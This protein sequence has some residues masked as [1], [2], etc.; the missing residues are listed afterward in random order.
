MT[1]YTSGSK[2]LKWEQIGFG[3]TLLAMQELRVPFV[4]EQLESMLVGLGE[5]FMQFAFSVPG[6]LERTIKELPSLC[7]APLFPISRPVITGT[8]HSLI[9][10]IQ[11]VTTA[12]VCSPRKRSVRRR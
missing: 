10:E 7:P 5:Q 8:S 12:K 3:A 6:Y 9:R 2:Q 1:H 11:A 4:R